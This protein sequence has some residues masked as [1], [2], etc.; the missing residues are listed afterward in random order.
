MT[1]REKINVMDRPVPQKL[2]QRHPLSHG[3]PYAWDAVYFITIVAAQR[4][5]NSLAV[6][7]L[8][9][10]L[11]QEWNGYAE[12]QACAPLLFVVMPDHVHGL[13]RFSVEPGM[14]TTVRAWKRLIARRYGVTWQRDFFDHRLRND[15]SFDEKVAYIRDN[16]V[17]KE[18]VAAAA[19]WPYAWPR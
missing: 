18:L 9:P 7:Q 5:V 13:F 10:L 6:P 12:I 17:R 16:P 1:R 19:A 2:P 8:A 14:A 15:E 11:W 3:Q 4:G